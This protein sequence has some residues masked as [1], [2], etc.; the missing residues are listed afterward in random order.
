LCDDIHHMKRIIA[1]ALLGSALLFGQTSTSAISGTVSDSSGAVVP[2]ASVTLTNEGTGIVQTQKTTQAG[3]YSFPALVIGTYSVKVEMQGF[4]T[5]NRTGNVLEVATPLEINVTLEIGQTGEVVTVEARAEA[6]QTSDASVGNV[7]TQQEIKEIPLNG[8]NP[9]ALLVLEPGV[10]QLSGGS[11]GTGVHVNG[12]RDMAS[13]TT[14]DGIDANESSVGNPSNNVY[15]LNPDNVQE[16]KVTTNNQTAE[17]GRSSGAA[18]SVAT[19]SGTN[20]FHGTVFE[21]LRN[22]AL[23]SSEFFANAMGN[24]KPDIKLNM[25]GFSVGGPIRRNRTFFAGSWQGQKINFAQPIDQVYSGMPTLYTPTALS[26][27]YR[28]FVANPRS[29]LVLDGQT[30]TRNVPSLVDPKSG[31][32]RAGLRACGSNTDLNC[33]QT[34]NM[35]ANDPRRIGADPTIM[36]LFKSLP[37]VNSYTAGDGLNYG[38]YSWNSPARKRGPSWMARVDHNFNGSNNMFVR[39]LR[40]ENN[41][42]GG[43]P[44]NSRP[45]VYPGFPPLGEVYRGSHNLAASYK[46]VISPRMINDLTFGLSRF[47][48]LFTQG[49]A[50]PDFPNAP[51]FSRAA[52]TGFNYVDAPWRNVPRTFRVVTTPQVIDNLTYLYGGHQIKAGFN[53]RLYRHNDQRGQPG[54]ATVT[55]LLTF[56]SGLRAPVGYTLPAQSTTSAGGINPTDFTRL[57]GTINDIMGMPTRLSQSF[58][59]DLVHDTFAPFRAGNGVNLWSMGHRLKQYNWFVQDE[60]KLSRSLTLN[61]GVRWELNMAPTEAGGRVYVPNKPVTGS[62]GPLTYVRANSWIDHNNLGTGPRLSISWKALPRTVI[63]TGYTMAFDPIASFQVTN[64]A[65][66]VPGLTTTCEARVGGATTP[67]CYGVPDVRYSEGFPAELKVPDV[68]PSSFLTP[69]AVVNSNAPAITVFDP[70]IGMPMVHMW[71]FSI[72]H[73]LPRSMVGQVSYVARRGT[74]LYRSYDINQI[75]SDAILPSFLA[76]QRNVAKGCRADG[77]NCPSGSGEP[78][79][80]VTQGITNATFVNSATTTNDLLLNGAG[81]FAGRLENSTLNSRLRP[82]QQFAKISYIDAGGDSYYHSMQMTLRKRFSDG[83][84]LGLAYTL[85]K[86]IDD[87]SSDPVAASSTGGLTTT[88]TRSP[89][90]IRNWR[91]ER[92]VSTFDRTH[93]VN[94][95]WI[96]ELPVGKRKRFSSLPRALNYVIGNWSLNGILMVASGSPFTVRSGNRTANYSHESRADIVG[97]KLPETGLFNV[98]N[99]IGPVYFKDA[100]AFTVP[101]PGSPGMGRNLFRGPG[102][103][104]LDTG[105]TKSFRLTEKVDVQFRGEVFN[106]LNHPNFDNPYDASNGSASFRST[107]FAQACCTLVSPPSTRAIVDTGEAGRIVQFAL[108]LRF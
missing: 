92:G 2:A 82:N 57:Q 48:F 61:Y 66:T 44:N 31:E 9:L 30:I 75:N 94:A 108:K 87:Q 11:D 39:Y 38:G 46:R 86:S 73:E 21:F 12:S 43:D 29:P 18:V 67:G 98:P 59:G 45:Q 64:V 56:D 80:I 97:G 74:R 4:K 6:L 15:R 69:P 65:G 24:P 19:P 35:F 99:V 58:L 79:P 41:T 63:R 68:K 10:V 104:N 101:A 78:I 34:Y 28:Y 85:S 95:T 93:V 77:T 1:L 71:N 76:M 36:K 96:Y 54:G 5:V 37:A 25:Y 53:A 40:G 20:K 106:T 14:I 52:G 55:P 81:N 90:D 50:N 33:I 91:L 107:V 32:L 26:G 3:V 102:Y 62:Q 17:Q 84:L 70:R 103:W 89:T 105:L 27:V 51:A 88:N 7:I 42:L 23:N 22:T 13:N 16:Y 72:Q 47:A 49:E 60:W 100:S 83:M 8:R